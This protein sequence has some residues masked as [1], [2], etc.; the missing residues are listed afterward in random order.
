MLDTAH[1]DKYND[2]VD[3]CKGP[4]ITGGL[5]H[6]HGVPPSDAGRPTGRF[7]PSGDDLHVGRVQGKRKKARMLWVAE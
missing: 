7:A 3:S 6:V 2:S 1:L 4:R 5:W